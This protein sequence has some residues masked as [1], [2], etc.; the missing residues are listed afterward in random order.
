MEIPKIELKFKYR[1]KEYSGIVAVPA[2][3]EQAR[4]FMKEEE[5]YNCFVHGYIEEQ[6]R[7]IRLK[8]IK[9]YVK[10]KLDDLSDEQKEALKTLGII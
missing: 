9:K 2:S 7:K 3:I 10:L 4:L 5:I 1:G 6:K 8:R